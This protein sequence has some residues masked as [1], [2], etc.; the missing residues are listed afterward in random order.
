LDLHHNRENKQ[1]FVI[2]NKYTSY[3]NLPNYWLT[4]PEYDFA[5]DQELLEQTLETALEQGILLDTPIPKWA[6]LIWLT[7]HQNYL[8]H[9]TGN[10]SIQL[11]EPKKADDTNWFGNQNA[12]YAASDGIWAMFYAILDRPKIPMSISNGAVQITLEPP[13]D[14][15]FFS[16]QDTALEQKPFCTGWVYV[17]PKQGFSQE[18]KG[19]RDGIPYATHHWANLNPVKPLFSIQVEPS[20]FPFLHQIR[21]HNNEI[22][23]K[24]VEA[25]PNG[26]PWIEE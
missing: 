25:N 14:I 21:S 9:G 6:F 11:F 4:R 18:P 24:K 15:Y 12:V 16:V 22:L 5:Q 8:V 23:W 3:M 20:D 1:L 17:L 10:S 13:Q 7:H 19:Q 2:T 26:F